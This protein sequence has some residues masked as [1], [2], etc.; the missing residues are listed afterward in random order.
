METSNC[1]LRVPVNVY[2]FEGL[3]KEGNMIKYH[4]DEGLFHQTCAF[5]WPVLIQIMRKCKSLRWN[6]GFPGSSACEEP[7][8]NAGDLG[9][10]PGPGRSPGDGHGNPLKYSCLENPHGR[11]AWRATVHDVAKSW[12]QLKQLS[13]HTGSSAR[14]M[15]QIV[16]L[17]WNILACSSRS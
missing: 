4:N 5:P 12:A 11:G 17:A 13:M 15:E 7:A 14:S 16:F 8:Y 2:G 9:L 6:L 3:K 10:I 1:H